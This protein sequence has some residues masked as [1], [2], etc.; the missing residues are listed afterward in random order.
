M[1]ETAAQ[2]TAEEILQVL[3]QMGQTVSGR[4]EI[5]KTDPNE[6]YPGLSDCIRKCLKTHGVI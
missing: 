2:M 6:R 4:F 1:I 3:V 5:G